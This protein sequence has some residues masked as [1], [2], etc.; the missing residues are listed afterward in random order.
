MNRVGVAGNNMEMVGRGENVA[1][2]TQTRERHVVAVKTFGAVTLCL[3]ASYIPAFAVASQSLR[4]EFLFLYYINHLCNPFIYFSF[5]R[6]F[7]QSVF[8]VVR[9]KCKP[10]CI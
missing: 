9:R 6:E 5:N 10:N 7:R 1:P 3:L 4:V 8:A 2:P